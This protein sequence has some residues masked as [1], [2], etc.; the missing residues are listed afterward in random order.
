MSTGVRGRQVYQKKA[1]ELEN[2]NNLFARPGDTYEPICRQ[3]K[4]TALCVIRGL[5]EIVTGDLTR[6]G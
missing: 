3:E 1:E 5:L 4:I 2:K 6:G